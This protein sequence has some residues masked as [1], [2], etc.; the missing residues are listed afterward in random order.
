MRF[1]ALAEM[2]LQKSVR[3]SYSSLAVESVIEN[4]Y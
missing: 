4:V 2:V 3:C 1:S